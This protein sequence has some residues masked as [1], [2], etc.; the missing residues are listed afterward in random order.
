MLDAEVRRRI[1][2]YIHSATEWGLAEKAEDL[3]AVLA[4]CD[5]LKKELAARS[6]WTDSG[7]WRVSSEDRGKK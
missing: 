5:R 7:V 4:E 3:R 1:E 6:V 2:G